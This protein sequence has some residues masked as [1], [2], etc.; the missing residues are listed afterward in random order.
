MQLSRGIERNYNLDVYTTAMFFL[1]PASLRTPGVSQFFALRVVTCGVLAHML[2]ATLLRTHVP[3]YPTAQL[4]A[5]EKKCAKKIPTTTW[6][7]KWVDP[8]G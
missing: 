4:V 5:F 2:D 3:C 6:G 7:L 1:V 8:W